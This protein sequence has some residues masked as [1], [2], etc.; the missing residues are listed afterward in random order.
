MHSYFDP[1]S[2]QMVTGKVQSE[3]GKKMAAYA[4]EIGDYQQAHG[5]HDPEAILKNAYIAV[6]RDFAISQIEQS[7]KQATPLPGAATT[8]A[9]AATPAQ[10]PQEA[11]NA[12]FLAAKNPSGK[13]AGGRNGNMKP[14]E[15][16]VTSKNIEKIMLKRL[17]E[18]GY[19]K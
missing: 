3:W 2:G 15:E 8:A 17:A 16:G 7:K 10:T 9:A 6:Q 5:F 13:S 12:K 4:K 18:A 14:A 11:A 1:N 19:K